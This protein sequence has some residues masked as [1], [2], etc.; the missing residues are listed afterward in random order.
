MWLAGIWRYPVKSMAGE[1]LQEAQLTR[2]GITG[3]RIIHVAD[4]QGSLKT[5]R[6]Y[7]KLLGLH[8]T[9]SSDGEPLVNG[10]HWT[11]PAILPLLAEAAGE[12]AQLVRY[13]GPERFD[14]LPLLI[15]TD[16]ALA[17]LGHDPRR[18]RP[19]LVIGG[20]EGLAERDWEGRRLR[21]GEAIIEADDLRARCVMT[22]F[23]PDTQA[24]DKNV[25]K[26]IG[27]RFGG[28]FGLN[29]AVVTGGTIRVGDTVALLDD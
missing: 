8:A 5:A 17:V 6:R 19:N 13:E 16:G 14:V 27:R 28:T 22:T 7:G 3:D 9:T 10:L 12:G 29:T 21:V 1:R 4:E 25:L 23:D 2:N 20:V 26:D 11:D 18:L 15:T 24:Q